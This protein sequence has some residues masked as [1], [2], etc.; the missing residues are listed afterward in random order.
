MSLTELVASQ[1]ETEVP[2]PSDEDTGM[3]DAQNQ[4]E[5]ASETPVNS[6]VE[7]QDI[8]TSE[9]EEGRAPKRI[10]KLLDERRALND[11]LLQERAAREAIERNMEH[12]QRNDD[13]GKDKTLA[14][15]DVAALRDFMDKA[16]D[17][18]DLQE[19]IPEAQRYLT[20]KMIQEGIDKYKNEQQVTSSEKQGQDLTNLMLNNLAG[21]RL[22]DQ[23]SDYF[24]SVQATLNELDGDQ[25]KNVN[26]DQLLA[27]ALAE[28]DRLKNT[29][30]GPTVSDRV[31]QNRSNNNKIISNNRAV[32]SGSGDLK[33]YLAEHKGGLQ[34]GKQG[35][36]TSDIKEAIGRLG[37]MKEFQQ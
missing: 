18:E 3:I 35:S 25:F 4:G 19:H 1:P 13:G 31:V 37:I 36:T 5:Q 16:R 11:E 6:D 12:F 20:E 32:S 28:V 21:E 10:K 33:S 15:L 30:A 27:V 14:D 29:Q 9:S 2:T 26:K 24:S 34:R 23:E 7:D 22:R 17:N 8:E